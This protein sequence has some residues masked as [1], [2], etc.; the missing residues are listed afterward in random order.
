MHIV[1][2]KVVI[3]PPKACRSQRTSF[4]ANRIAVEDVELTNQH[5]RLFNS[6]RLTGTA[7]AINY[8]A[9]WDLTKHN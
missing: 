3:G 1:G 7:I 5:L 6:L 9:I 2:H 8:E 4:P